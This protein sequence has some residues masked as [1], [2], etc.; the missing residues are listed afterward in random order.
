MSQ[1]GLKL[2]IVLNDASGQPTALLSPLLNLTLLPRDIRAIANILDPF[3]PGRLT[4]RGMF[5][6]D[7]HCVYI[8]C[9]SPKHPHRLGL[10][11]L[12]V[13][14]TYGIASFDE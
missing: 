5:F 1:A 7:F 3:N 11:S 8:R 4:Q 14:Y 2:D 13:P 6:A 10:C 9:S 12:Y